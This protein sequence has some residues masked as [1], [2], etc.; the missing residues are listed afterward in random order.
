M[1]TQRSEQDLL[2]RL[3]S[4]LER[5]GASAFVHDLADIRES[6]ITTKHKEIFDTVVSDARGLRMEKHH[7]VRITLRHIANERMRVLKRGPWK[8]TAVATGSGHAMRV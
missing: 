6:R 1:A 7:K 5:G 2:D 4:L 3:K 8:P